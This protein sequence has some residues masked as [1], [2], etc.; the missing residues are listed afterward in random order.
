MQQPCFW[1]LQLKESCRGVGP[2]TPNAVC[3]NMDLCIVS[4]T[5]W[6]LGSCECSC[7]CKAAHTQVRICCISFYARARVC[8][9]VVYLPIYPSI[10]PSITMCID[11]RRDSYAPMCTQVWKLRDW[12]EAM[13]VNEVIC[14]YVHRHEQKERKTDTEKQTERTQTNAQLASWYSA[15]RR[16]NVGLE[17]RNRS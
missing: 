8:V 12:R 17:S 2:T 4:G 10:H 7:I 15:S 1:S 9:C 6:V 13:L 14:M 16:Q 5:L 3:R 11:A